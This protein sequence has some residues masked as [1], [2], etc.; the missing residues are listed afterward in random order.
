MGKWWSVLVTGTALTSAFVPGATV[1]VVA[2][3]AVAGLAGL[4]AAVVHEG[5]E[6]ARARGSGA[7]ASLTVARFCDDLALAAC[8]SALLFATTPFS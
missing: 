3:M 4:A 8:F 6:Y 7:P 2:S 5:A 1:G